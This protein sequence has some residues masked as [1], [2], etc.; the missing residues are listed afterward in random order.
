MIEVSKAKSNITLNDI[1]DF[2]NL[3]KA[4]ATIFCKR[5]EIKKSV[6]PQREPFWMH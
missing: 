1:N 2:K 5:M 4:G 3:I 6:K